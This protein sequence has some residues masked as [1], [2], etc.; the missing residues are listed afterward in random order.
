MGSYASRTDATQLQ[1]HTLRS[2]ASAGRDPLQDA[3]HDR[4]ATLKCQM[5][6]DSITGEAAAGGGNGGGGGGGVCGGG[7]WTQACVCTCARVAGMWMCT[8]VLI[9]FW[10]LRC[11][12]HVAVA[13]RESDGHP[14]PAHLQPAATWRLPWHETLWSTEA[15]SVLSS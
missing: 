1:L 14:R 9:L 3:V 6:C 2:A 12:V 7:T 13:M 4:I 15:A 5:R 8:H 10:L 11:T